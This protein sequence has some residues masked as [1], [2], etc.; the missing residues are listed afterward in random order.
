MAEE[1]WVICGGKMARSY[2]RVI[3]AKPYDGV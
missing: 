3:A 1:E 2:I